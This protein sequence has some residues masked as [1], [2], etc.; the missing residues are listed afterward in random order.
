MVKNI[1]QGVWFM[2]VSA[3]YL[4]FM[5]AFAKFLAADMPTV[6]IVFFRNII[7]VLLISATFFKVPVRQEGGKPWLLLFRAGVGLI[8]M[9]SFFYNVANISLADAVTYSRMSPIFTAIFAM[10]FLRE[11]IGKKGWLAIIIGFVG[12]LL[13]MQ[14]AGLSVEESHVFG[15][16]NAVCAA[17][18]FTSIRELNKY[19]NTRIIVLSFMGIGILVPM[20]SMMISPYYG[21]ETLNFMMGEFIM[22]EGMQWL[23][24]LAIGVTASLAQIYMTK[25]Y[26]QTR[27]GIV[28]AAGY[29]VIIFSLIIGVV[30]GDALPSLLGVIGI[31]AVISGGV[32]I[33]RERA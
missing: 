7:G 21:S 9:L 31:M 28:G 26:G 23:Y 1:N 30:L 20:I 18:A 5:S 10:W 16:L 11:R 33:A 3:F 12:M 13:V 32:L 22:P 25:A 19:Y 29:S 6:E 14:P 2:L 27:A 24:L 4:A 8:A 15:L 17:L